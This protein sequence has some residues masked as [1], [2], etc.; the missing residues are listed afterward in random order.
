MKH[1]SRKRNSGGSGAAWLLQDKDGGY[2]TASAGDVV[3]AVRNGLPVA[4]FERLRERYQVS[5]DKMA[6]IVRIPRST[7][8]RRKKGGILDRFES[9]R[10]VRF[11]RLLTIATEV[12]EDGNVARDWLTRPARALG[13]ETPLDYADTEVGAREVENLLGRL[14]H[15][16]FT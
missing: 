10:V 14:E 3:A 9:E 13:G 4:A 15:G 1:G 16:V 11:D 8:I 5:S 6:E 2:A 12:L 7:M